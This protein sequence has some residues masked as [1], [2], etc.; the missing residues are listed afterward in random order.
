M[1]LLIRSAYGPRERVFAPLGGKART[2]G[3]MQDECD[4]NKIMLKYQKTGAV[5]HLNRHGADYGFASGLD[6]SESMRVVTD[7]QAMFD[8]LP[9]SVRARFGNSP[10]EFL[11]FVQDPENQDEAVKLGLAE[12]NG[13]EVEV[14]PAV[15][16]VVVTE[17]PVESGDVR[18]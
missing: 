6:F 18:V 1:E 11:D 8:D 9:S 16:P 17:D 10:S 7:A 15:P 4:I 5:S 3:S 2:K 14:V 13:A 12:D